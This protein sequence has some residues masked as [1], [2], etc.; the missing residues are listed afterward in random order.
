MSEHSTPEQRTEMPTD[1]RMSMLRREGALFI[2]NDVVNVVS[3][4]AGFYMLKLV[5]GGIFHNL[6]LAMARCFREIG[7]NRPLTLTVLRED[8]FNLMLLLMP[9]VLLMVAVVAAFSSLAVMLQTNFNFKERKIQFKWDLIHPI[10][11]LRRIFSISGFVNTGKAILKLTL[12]LPIA[13]VAL[14]S[15]APFM[16][17]LIHMSLGDLF[18]FSRDAMGNLF[19]KIMYVLIAMAVFD[20]VYGKFMWLKHNKMTK[21][22]VK[23]EKKA[24][25]GD[26]E[27]RRKIMWKGLQRMM[28]RIKQ[29][30]RQADVVITNPTHYAI[31]LKY[32]RNSMEAPV[33]VA[34]GRGHMALRIRKAAKEMGIPVLERKTLARAL[35]KSCEVGSSIPYELFKAVA[36]VL[37]YVYRLKRSGYRPPVIENPVMMED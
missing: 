5:W 17:S 3:L 11:G 10:N 4:L 21:D 33:I 25:E 16:L 37:A 15:Y 8:V 28:Q 35:Y 9:R 19:W 26:E 2:S 18:E 12:I 20:F 24:V 1:K 14:K 34:K 36:E 30:V 13:Y 31:A 23:D 29:G 22:E 32:D 6:G 7:E 27:T